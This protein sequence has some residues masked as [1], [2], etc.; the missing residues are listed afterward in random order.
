[1]KLV[2]FEDVI[3]DLF[4]DSYDEIWNGWEFILWEFRKQTYELLQKF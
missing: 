1:M 3:S 4:D 2:G